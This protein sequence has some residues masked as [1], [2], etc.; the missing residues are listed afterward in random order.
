[1]N[2]ELR[3]EKVRKDR[4][5]LFS[6]KALYERSFPENERIPFHILLQMKESDALFYA[7]YGPEGL[8]G[9]YHVFLS[10]TLLY[11]SYICIREDLKGKG[12]GTKILRHIH[13]MLEGK[14]IVIDIEEVNQEDANYVEELRRRYFYVNNGY[15]STGIFYHFFDVDYELLSYGGQVNRQMWIDLTLKIWGKRA[16]GARYKEDKG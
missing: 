10:E 3:Y 1:M 8:I 9:L 13:E 16:K 6:V 4:H 12:Y 2:K 11:L 7:V 14:P 15:V 5:D